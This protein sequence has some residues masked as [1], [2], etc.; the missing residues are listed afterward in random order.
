MF[1]DAMR[2]VTS[3]NN[4]GWFHPGWRKMRCFDTTLAPS[5]GLNVIDFHRVGVVRSSVPSNHHNLSLSFTAS[6]YVASVVSP[7]IPQWPPRTPSARSHVTVIDV[8]DISFS[9]VGRWDSKLQTSND[10]E[11]WVVNEDS[12]EPPPKRW[13]FCQ[14]FIGFAAVLGQNCLV[15]VNVAPYCVCAKLSTSYDETSI[16]VVVCSGWLSEE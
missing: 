6:D 13:K 9:I 11:G 2:E 3:L 16:T 15:R 8:Q 4:L 7:A 1:I 10:H 5:S 12:T 14:L